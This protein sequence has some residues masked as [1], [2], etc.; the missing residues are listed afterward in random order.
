MILPKNITKHTAHNCCTSA[1]CSDTS[2]FHRIRSYSLKPVQYR[3]INIYPAFLS[4]NSHWR[5]LQHVR[6]NEKSDHTSSDV[7]LIELANTPIAPSDSNP[8]QGD[9][10]RVL[11]Y[12][13]KGT[14]QWCLSKII[15]EETHLL[16]K[17]RGRAG[18]SLALR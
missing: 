18:P 7:H 3:S 1:S 16:P 15:T 11:G 10:Q 8:L 12:R 4:G 17:S 2:S 14:S 9:V 13:T 6:H 5:V